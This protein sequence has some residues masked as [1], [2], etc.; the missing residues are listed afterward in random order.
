VIVRT[1]YTSCLARRIDSDSFRLRRGNLPATSEALE[2]LINI[3]VSRILST[4]PLVNAGAHIVSGFS[5]DTFANAALRTTACRVF[6]CEELP[7][8]FVAS[9]SPHSRS[10]AQPSSSFSNGRCKQVY[11]RKRCTLPGSLGHA[12]PRVRKTYITAASI[13]TSH[14]VSSPSRMSYQGLFGSF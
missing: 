5:E 6:G 1:L 12:K 9:E 14:R 10:F 4:T 8:P 11:H 3:C 13:A 2:M 7:E